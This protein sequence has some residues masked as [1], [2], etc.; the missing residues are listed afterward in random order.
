MHDLHIKC[1]ARTLFQALGTHSRAPD[2]P[3]L[4]AAHEPKVLTRRRG[5]AS[6]SKL[7]TR[8]KSKPNCA[9]RCSDN[10][11]VD[12]QNLRLSSILW[13]NI[14]LRSSLTASALYLVRQCYGTGHTC[15]GSPDACRD[16][17]RH[18]PSP[19]RKNNHL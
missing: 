2:Y 12:E 19:Y 6:P 5:K 8:S 4:L 1:G 16:Q 15:T 9:R 7:H 11:N 17:F 10:V 14:S 18:G 3:S 13:T